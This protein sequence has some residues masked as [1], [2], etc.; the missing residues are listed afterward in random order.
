MHIQ[1]ECQVC[2][3][4]D[5]HVPQLLSSF[6]VWLQFHE[7]REQFVEV[8]QIISGGLLQ[9]EELRGSNQTPIPFDKQQKPCKP[10]LQT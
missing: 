8:N 3:K 6:Q 5:L 9:K 2:L 1:S 10:G 4:Q 7:E